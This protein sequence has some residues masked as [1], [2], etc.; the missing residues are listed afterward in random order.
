MEVPWTILNQTS[1]TELT[2]EEENE[3]LEDS[4]ENLKRSN[5]NVTNK[6]KPVITN[7]T[8]IKTIT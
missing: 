2:Q 5:D 8:N 1:N 6:G 4:N 7:I 3:L